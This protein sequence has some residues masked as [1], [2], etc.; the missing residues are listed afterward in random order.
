MG[1]DQ[2]DASNACIPPTHPLTYQALPLPTASRGETIFLDG[3]GGRLND[4]DDQRAPL[5]MYAWGKLIVVREIELY[6][7][8]Q[9]T[10][11]TTSCASSSRVG[12]SGSPSTNGFVYRG[13]SA[14]VTAAKFSP[15]GTYVASGDSKGKLRIWAWDHEEHLPKIELQVLAGPIKDISW[16]FEGKRIVVIGDGMQSPENAKVVQWDTGVKCGDLGAHARKKGRLCAFRPCR[17]MRI[18]TGGAEDATVMFHQGPPFQ[19]VVG[20]GIVSEKCHER[21]AIHSLRYNKDGSVL[22]SAGTDGSVIF[23]DGKS[24]HL[25][26]KVEKVHKSSIFSCAWNRNGTHLLTCGADGFARLVDAMSGETV[27]EWDVALTQLGDDNVRNKVPMGAMLLGCAFL[28][29]DIPIAVGFNGQIVVLSVPS[30]IGLSSL[31]EVIDKPLVI[32]GHQ[33]PISAMTFGAPGS[34]VIYT[35]D[36]DGVLVEWDGLTGI[37]RGRVKNVGEEDVELT[38]RVHSGAT[39]TSL[40]FSSESSKLYS[41]GWDDFIRIS[42]GQNCV[43]KLKMKAQPNDMACGTSL[44]VV[45]TVEGLVL[46]KDEQ[47][48]SELIRLPYTATAIC[49]SKDETMLYVGGD[50]CNIYIYTVSLSDS[51]NPL[52]ESHVIKGG[53]MKAVQ[54]IALSHDR[55]KLA[56]A[57]SRDVCVYSTT[58]YS[59]IVSKGRWC[60][61]TQRISCLTWSSDDSILAS[62]G[63]DDDIFLWNIQ[64]KMRRIHY[65]FAHRGGI[66][67]LRFVGGNAADGTGSIMLVSV[68]NDGCVN[69]WDVKEDVSNKFQ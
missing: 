14:P 42:Q 8:N 9:T 59:T 49:I 2:V 16:D 61:H 55:T 65:R 29:G 22:A 24:M 52:A 64:K 43:N 53:H 41:A 58:D 47:I 68:G 19:R 7:S 57:D 45:M 66:T 62:G 54:S 5:I 15:A 1:V 69:F 39:I 38:G 25:M 12:P 10:K 33:A 6:S 26:K 51:V 27:H 13:H 67:G 48:I 34:N 18:A 31:A 11:K 46:V 37:P 28:K 44:L 21:G 50:D 4:N 23:Y 63:N 32:T 35:A 3:Q 30:S 36:T 60:F 40:A 20:D 56:A 17:P